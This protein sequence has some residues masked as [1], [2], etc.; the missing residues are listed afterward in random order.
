MAGWCR[1][2]CDLRIAEAAIAPLTFSRQILA[3]SSACKLRKLG[4]VRFP[5]GADT[6]I[7]EERLWLTCFAR[8]LRK[9]QPGDQRSYKRSFRKSRFALR[10]AA[11]VT[12]DH[13]G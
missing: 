8:I 11:S 6:D 9:R 5:I 2:W 7:A 13:P 3:H 1:W 12:R 4:V 10:S